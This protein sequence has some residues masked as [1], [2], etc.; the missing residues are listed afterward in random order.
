[1]AERTFHQVM[2]V[3]GVSRDLPP[4][5]LSFEAIILGDVAF[6]IGTFDTYV[7]TNKDYSTCFAEFSTRLIIGDVP[8]SGGRVMRGIIHTQVAT[9]AEWKARAKASE[10]KVTELEVLYAAREVHM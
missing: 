10:A 2:P 4:H 7:D 1:M 5:G 3:Y 8:L 6:A 9:E